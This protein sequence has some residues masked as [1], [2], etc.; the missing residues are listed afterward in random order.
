MKIQLTIVGLL[1]VVHCT[2][3]YKS[4]VITVDS[5]TASV[6]HSRAKIFF[7]HA[8]KNPKYATQVADD[9]GK[10]IIVKGRFDVSPHGWPTHQSDISFMFTISSREGRYK[11]DIDNVKFNY[12]AGS[13]TKKQES[14][15]SATEGKG[16]TKKQWEK[17][18]EQA[19]E[20]FSGLIADLKSTMNKN[21]KW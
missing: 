15:I 19:E 3:Q 4:E 21:D 11:Y 10:T 6:L 9:D 16:V 1:F 2:A 18:K 13:L 7:A 17:V 20:V 5:T 12:Q 8:F 14:D